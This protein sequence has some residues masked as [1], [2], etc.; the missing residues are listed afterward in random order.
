[1]PPKK[2]SGGARGGSKATKARTQDQGGADEVE[3]GQQQDVPGDTE[4]VG[5]AAV[6]EVRTVKGD[7]PLMS[8][9][10]YEEAADFVE[11]HPILWDTTNPDWKRQDLK[12]DAWNKGAKQFGLSM[13]L[14]KVWYNTVRTE[15]S[16]ILKDMREAKSGSG[17]TKLPKKKQW[18]YDRYAF[19][20]GFIH[21][22]DQGKEM[23]SVSSLFIFWGN[24]VG[25]WLVN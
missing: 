22:R 15:L 17:A 18:I 11:S 7:M 9:D 5:Q 19:M 13:A 4:E 21:G 6:P 24:K 8:R 10:R 16:R 1:M 23:V 12:L 25:N 20:R 3:E 2:P 14:F